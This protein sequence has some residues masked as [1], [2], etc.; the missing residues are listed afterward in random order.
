MTLT[1]NNKKPPAGKLATEVRSGDAPK[2]SFPMKTD[3]QLQ[4][5]WKSTPDQP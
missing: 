1:N 4:K 5:I 2:P 3:E